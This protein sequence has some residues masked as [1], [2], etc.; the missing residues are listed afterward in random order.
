LVGVAAS[1]VGLLLAV[2]Y[3][4]REAVKI[5]DLRYDTRIAR[6]PVVSRPRLKGYGISSAYGSGSSQENIENLYAHGIVIINRGHDSIRRIDIAPGNPLRVEVKGARLLDITVESA[7]RDVINFSVGSPIRRD[8]SV[9]EAEVSFDYLDHEDGALVRILTT[10]RPESLAVVGDIVG[11]PKGIRRVGDDHR[12]NVWG[13]LGGAVSVLLFVASLSLTPFVYR[14]VTGGWENVWI[15]ALPIL[16]LILPLVIIIVIG[17]TV[18]PSGEPSLPAKIS[19]HR[20]RF[21]GL[22][23]PP[24]R[25]DAFFEYPYALLESPNIVDGDD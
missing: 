12:G 25:H 20:G 5:K 24:M 3:A 9:T 22:G 4:R 2:I 17:S 8:K 6:F 11:M 23:N 21:I 16:A 19:P 13:R 18:W 1:I 15:L 14:R 7:T 10:E